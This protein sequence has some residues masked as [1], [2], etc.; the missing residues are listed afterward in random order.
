MAHDF[1]VVEDFNW[2]K[3]IVWSNMNVL[4]VILLAPWLSGIPQRFYKP[5]LHKED[6]AN[7]STEY[8]QGFQFS[9]VKVLWL[10]IK[11]VQC[12]LPYMFRMNSVS[13]PK[14]LVK[15]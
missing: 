7:S 5:K 8:E 13:F 15:L 12:L 4:A 14:M 9:Q 3:K 10:T 11:K 2:K 6:I 1:I